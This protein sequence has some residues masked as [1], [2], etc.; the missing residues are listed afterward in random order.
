MPATNAW[1]R[2]RFL[3]SPGWRSDPVAPDVERQRRVV[4]IGTLVVATEARDGPVDAGRAQVDLAHLGRVAVADLGVGVVGRHP[5]CAA[6]ST[7]PHRAA[8]RARDPNPRTTAVL[9]GCLSPGPASWKRPVSIGLT[10]IAVALELDRAGT[11]RVAGSAVDPLPDERLELRRACRG[12]RAAPARRAERIGRPASAAWRASATT[13]RSG[14][15]GHGRP[16]VADCERET[17]CA[18]LSRPREA[19]Q[20]K[21]DRPAIST[22]EGADRGVDT[23]RTT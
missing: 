5:R 23:P 10:T 8:R 16:I 17:A 13:V 21:S 18:R 20:L 22:H 6:R 7:R 2:S 11:C 9:V 4:G 3:S 12:R 1:L 19:G 14:K 15:F